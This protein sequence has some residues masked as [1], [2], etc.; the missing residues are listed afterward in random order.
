MSFELQAL[1]IVPGQPHPLLA[2]EKSPAWQS[3]AKSY[4]KLR[5]DIEMLDPE[6]ILYFSTQWLSVLGW[7][8]Q[9]DPKPKWT[10]VDP[11]W[12]ELGTM[13]YEFVVDSA[14][15]FVHEQEVKKTGRFTRTVNYEGFP[16]DTGTIVAQKLLNPD[17]K[18]PASM[19]SCNMYAEKE[20]TVAIGEASF[21]ALQRHGKRAIVVL[22][23]NLSN[24]YFIEEIDP[25]KDRISSRK[26]DEWNLKIL[27]LLGEGRLEDVAQ[28]AREFS[29]E[30]NG[31]MQFKGV[32]WL[33]ALGGECNG[34]EGKVYDYQ[35]VWGTGCGIAMLKP[36]QSH[37]SKG[38]QSAR[39]TS[40]ASSVQ[41]DFPHSIKAEFVS[42]SAQ[43][44][45]ARSTA[46]Q[47]TE[48]T[49]SRKEA[50]VIQ[51]G[52]AAHAVGSYPHARR[53]GEFLFLSG[54]GPRRRDTNEI[55]GLV[56][57]ESGEVTSY[58][59]VAETHAVFDNIKAVL[60]SAGA[61][62]KDLIDVQVFLTD[63]KKDFKTFNQ[64]YAEYFPDSNVAPTRTTMGIAG[65]PT[66][67]HVELKVVARL[68]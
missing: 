33:N 5:A 37:P 53:E 19:I 32:W 47:V 2:P 38:S 59:I 55:P 51:S 49:D 10:H 52:Q 31:D 42:D 56:Q 8:F 17:N 13:P 48:S 6:I 58:D 30:A 3:L 27:E 21:Q 54:I 29:K 68:K 23:S 63:I 22:V 28:V 36:N 24:R 1:C 26:D 67:I 11:N 64:V 4:E 66:P 57:D 41:T 44:V 7:M 16:I 62:L 25:K 34:Y 18:Y 14:F 39:N 20:E 12:H 45:E 40:K 60:A 15:A 46:H 50:Q 9:A 65:L 35:P 61:S 43:K